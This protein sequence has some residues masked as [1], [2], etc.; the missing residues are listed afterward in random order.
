MTLIL[1]LVVVV[2]GFFTLAVAFGVTL[3]LIE[4]VPAL[5]AF[6]EVPE[7]EQ[8]FFVVTATTRT[9]LAPFGTLTLAVLL[10]LVKEV[11]L[12][13]FITA[14]FETTEVGVFEPVLTDDEETPHGTLFT[15]TQIV[16][17]AIAPVPR[18]RYFVEADGQITKVAFPFEPV[19]ATIIAEHPA[20]VFTRIARTIAALLI[21]LVDTPPFAQMVETLSVDPTS[22]PCSQLEPEFT[23]STDWDTPEI[24][25]LSSSTKSVSIVTP[26]VESAL[27]SV[28]G[29]DGSASVSFAGVVGSASGNV[30]LMLAM[31]DIGTVSVSEVKVHFLF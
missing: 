13:F 23:G 22:P 21:E 19:F 9:T 2:F 17:E 4:Q 27:M 7:I 29:V 26:P 1:I 15:R 18:M 3:T 28:S 10:M 20:L 11:T 6:T 30:A 12:P 5:R 16:L 25:A 24:G 8:N 14:T 31:N